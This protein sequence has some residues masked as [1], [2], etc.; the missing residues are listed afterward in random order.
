[1]A[2]GKPPQPISRRHSPQPIEVQPTARE[3]EIHGRLRG[4]SKRVLRALKDTDSYHVEAFVLE[5]L[6]KRALSSPYALRTSLQRRAENLG[7]GKVERTG[8]RRLE[9]LQQYRGDIVMTETD[10]SR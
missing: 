3:N 9:A 4:H 5:V 8:R 2:R 1:M 7:V 6:R 10:R